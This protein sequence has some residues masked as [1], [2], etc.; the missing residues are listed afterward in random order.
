M[1]QRLDM[2]PAAARA[3][4]AWVDYLRARRAEREAL[5]LDTQKE[6]GEFAPPPP[7]SNTD[8]RPTADIIAR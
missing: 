3:L 7:P 8:E 4:C 2:P 6:A 5:V 1:S